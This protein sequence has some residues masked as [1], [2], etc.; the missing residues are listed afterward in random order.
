MDF[1]FFGLSA[2]AEKRKT[3][4][5]PTATTAGIVIQPSARGSS[6]YKRVLDHLS[7]ATEGFV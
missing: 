7:K 4:A 5:P 1:S 2:N 6:E 3:M